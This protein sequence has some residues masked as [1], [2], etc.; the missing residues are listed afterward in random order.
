MKHEGKHTQLITPRLSCTFHTVTQSVWSC[1]FVGAVFSEEWVGGALQA[2][3]LR[4]AATVNVKSRLSGHPVDENSAI[5][6]MGQNRITLQERAM[7]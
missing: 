4:D 7:S 6:S 2:Q 5:K 3:L 1:V